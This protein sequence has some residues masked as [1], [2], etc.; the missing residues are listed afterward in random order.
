MHLA[1]LNLRFW[2]NHLGRAGSKQSTLAIANVAVVWGHIFVKRYVGYT[3]STLG[4]KPDTYPNTQLAKLPSGSMYITIMELGP[5]TLPEHH[6]YHGLWGPGSIA[7]T[8]VYTDPLSGITPELSPGCYH[9]SVLVFG[10]Q[11]NCVLGNRCCLQNRFEDFF[12]GLFIT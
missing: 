9:K 1:C 10:S 7:I 8:A 6:P 5:Q 3:R 4:S 2:R 12:Y 11:A